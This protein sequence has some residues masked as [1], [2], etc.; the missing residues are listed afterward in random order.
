MGRI[1]RRSTRFVVEWDAFLEDASQYCDF[2][3]TFQEPICPLTDSNFTKPDV[4]VFFRDP[5]EKLLFFGAD[6]VVLW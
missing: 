5:K 1:R 2:C 6:L 4:S 3:P